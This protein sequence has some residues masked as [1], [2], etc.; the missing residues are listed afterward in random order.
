MKIYHVP[1][2][3]VEVIPHGEFSIYKNFLKRN[4]FVNENE[5]LFFGRIYK[6]K[7]LEY[8]IRSEPLISKEI[9]DLKITIAGR[10]ENF[11]KYLK[12]IINKDKFTI[13][14]R[15]I[16]NEETA[17]LFQRCKIVVL[18]YTGASQSGVVPIAYAFNKPVV[19]TSVGSLGEVVYDGA[20]GFLVPPR[21]CK[22]LADAVVKILKDK[23]LYKNMSLNAHDKALNELS[24]DRIA[25]KT[26]SFY[27]KLLK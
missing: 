15:Y 7:G 5:I 17:E 11:K 14:N 3:Q 2:F 8:L 18:P 9:P 6:Y 22:A 27:E 26:I 10:G 21:D 25:D 12:L 4:V 19:A 20:T 16:S 23:E 1:D 13:M 24:W